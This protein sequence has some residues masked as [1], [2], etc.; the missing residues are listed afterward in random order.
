[1]EKNNR[2]FMPKTP[3]EKGLFAGTLVCVGLFTIC[4][5]FVTIGTGIIP[6]LIL[7]LLSLGIG[8]ALALYARKLIGVRLKEE[9]AAE[10]GIKQEEPAQAKEPE[11]VK[12][13]PIPEPAPA[14]AKEPEPELI[15]EP[16]P[17]VESKEPV[18]EEEPAPVP[19]APA[20]KSNKLIFAIV[21]PVAALVLVA[22]VAIPVAIHFANNNNEIR[23]DGEGDGGGKSTSKNNGGK[24]SFNVTSTVLYEESDTDDRVDGYQFDPHDNYVQYRFI[25][26]G[27]KWYVDWYEYGTWK[28]DESTGFIDAVCT[29]YKTYDS[30]SNKWN[31]NYYSSGA[32]NAQKRFK[33]INNTTLHWN[34][35]SQ[36]VCK[37]VT[38]FTHEIVSHPTDE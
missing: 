20:K 1:M 37:K 3:K 13:E 18:F 6:F 26:Y 33:V 16:E 36:F 35:N 24:V 7:A 29:Y 30:Y 34:G 14:P 22:A 27:T 31:E 5:I 8:M 38:S 23:D 2:K 9:E 15:P 4:L 17:V 10:G 19:P 21:I 32:S 28:F 11:P 12:E 25:R